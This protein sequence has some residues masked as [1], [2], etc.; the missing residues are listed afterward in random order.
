MK[1]DNLFSDDLW[2]AIEPLLPKK[3]PMPS[4][5]RP[6]APDLAVLAGIV[7]VL[8]T[9]IAWQMLP[10]EPGCGNGSICWRRFCEA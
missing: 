5:G 10:L 2:E 4:R 8:K 7:C 9:G 3:P 1:H 6:R